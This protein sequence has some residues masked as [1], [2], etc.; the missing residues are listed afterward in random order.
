[1]HQGLST[2]TTHVNVCDTQPHGPQILEW[3]I[4]WGCTGREPGQ[5]IRANF[6]SAYVLSHPYRFD[7]NL[8]VWS[9][10]FRV[11]TFR[12]FLLENIMRAFYPT[13]GETHVRM[14]LKQEQ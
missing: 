10:V 9:A 8:Q 6:S 14:K 2:R 4:C 12:K 11:E 13:S 7:R 1:M 5:K 3:Y